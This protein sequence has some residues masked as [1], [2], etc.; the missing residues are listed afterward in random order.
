MTCFPCIKCNKCRKL[1]PKID[2]VCSQCGADMPPGIP[3]CPKC[4]LHQEKVYQGFCP[5]SRLAGNGRIQG[6]IELRFLTMIL[7][8]I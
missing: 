5:E 4:G 2:I 3:S 7:A 8:A 1:I 6:A